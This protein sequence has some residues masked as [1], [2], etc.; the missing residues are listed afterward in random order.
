MELLG[1]INSE[2]GVALFMVTHSAA[3]SACASRIIEIEDGR[4]ISDAANSE[5]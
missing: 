3:H 4:I 2:R 5:D 1:R